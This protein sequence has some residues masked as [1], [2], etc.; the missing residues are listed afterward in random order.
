MTWALGNHLMQTMNEKK[1]S[2]QD[3]L[4]YVVAAGLLIVFYAM[5]RTLNHSESY[6]S[7]NYALFAENF[8]LGTAPDSRNILFHAFNRVLFVTSEWLG[9]GVGALELIAWV[10]IVTGAF[11][12]VLFARLMKTRFGVSSFAAWTGAAFLGLTYSFWRYTGAVFLILCSLTL[13]LNFLDSKNRRTLFA[14]SILSGL[15]VLFYQPNVIVLFFAAFVLFCSASLFVSFIRHAV[16]GAFVVL[17][18]IAMSL[19]MINGTFP[20][21]GELVDYVTSRNGEFGSRSPIHIAI[22]KLA[23]ALGHDFFS[24]H[25]TRTLEPVR[26]ALDPFVPGCIYNFNVV[27]FAGKGVQYL[28]AIAAILFVP[29]GFLFVR[30]HWIASRKWQRATPS[31]PTIFLIGWAGLLGLIVGTVDPGSFEAWIPVLIPLIGLFTVFVI[32][33]CCQLGKQ[34]TLITFLIV[35]F[36]YNFFGGIMLWRNTQGD[37]FLHK[38]AWI[39][40]NLTEKDTVVLN[41]FDY[42]IVDYLNYYSDAR[43]AHLTRDDRVVFYRS[44]PDIEHISVDEFIDKFGTEEH[45]LFALDDVLTPSPEIKSCRYGEAKYAAAEELANRLKEN[46]I[47]VNS[48]TFGDTYQIKKL[49]SS[50]QRLK[51][52]ELADDGQ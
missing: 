26:A 34:R 41:E 19:V 33:P 17:A 29:L 6:D 27:V 14:A 28:T 32:E 24:A 47:L 12:V 4:T 31:R 36:C 23:L 21:P 10:G 20:A 37:Y 7:I 38:T 52:P 35:L 46:A 40:Q 22:V 3:R 25:W 11:S 49:S 16:V 15:A 44:S 43:I 9:L 50:F 51:A 8:S 30:L 39:R 2:L 42:R 5:T 48:G 18:G 1:E 45:R 13:I